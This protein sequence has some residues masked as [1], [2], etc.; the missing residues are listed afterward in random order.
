M[1]LICFNSLNIINSIKVQKI[2]FCFINL[3]ANQKI[4]L[5]NF[6]ILIEC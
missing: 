6:K 5:N 4:K 3:Q 2:Y 1:N